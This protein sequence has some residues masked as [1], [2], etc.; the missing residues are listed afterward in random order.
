MENLLHNPCKNKIKVNSVNILSLQKSISF[1]KQNA[2]VPFIETI[3]AHINLNLN[4]KNLNTPLL[5]TITFP[6]KINNRNKIAVLATDKLIKQSKKI[7]ADIIITEDTINK[8]YHKNIKFN[9]LISTVEMIPKLTK[10]GKLLGPKGLM[11][12]LKSGT[13]I[14]KSEL[15]STVQEFKKGKFDYKIDKTGNIHLGF[16]KSN[17]SDTQLI[18]NLK[19]LYDSLKKNKP[20]GFKGTYLKTIHICTTMG[21]SIKLNLNLF[22]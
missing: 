22:N 13:L 10:L 12:S 2:T 18:D 11:P 21:P 17:F 6:H 7:G 5:K 4:F 1:L 8:L 9:V 15:R 14:K 19:F 16:G 3:E 20:A